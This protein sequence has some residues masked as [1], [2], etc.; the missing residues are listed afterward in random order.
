MPYGCCSGCHAPRSSPTLRSGSSCVLHP[1]SFIRSSYIPFHHVR[2]YTFAPGLGILPPPTLQL[3]AGCTIPSAAHCSLGSIP[4]LR[5]YFIS[6]RFSS[7][8]AY[9]IMLAGRPSPALRSFIGT[10][11][12]SCKHAT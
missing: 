10:K 4:L 11:P 1:A 9:F 6:A 2:S 7:P 8:A 5:R 12:G 3:W